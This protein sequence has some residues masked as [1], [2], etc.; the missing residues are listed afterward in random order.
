MTTLPGD[1][2]R[3]WPPQKALVEI[4]KLREPQVL[5]IPAGGYRFPV[6]VDPCLL[7]GT[8]E[9]RYGRRTVGRIEN[10]EP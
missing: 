5:I 8:V 1:P 3:D 10:I 7:L 4:M 9:F 6:E 2:F